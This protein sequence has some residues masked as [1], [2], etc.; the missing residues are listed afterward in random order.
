MQKNLIQLPLQCN[1]VIS[2]QIGKQL[3]LMSVGRFCF[4]LKV[5]SH[6][7]VRSIYHQ[8][9][10]FSPQYQVDKLNPRGTWK[11]GQ[12]ELGST[13]LNDHKLLENYWKEQ[14]PDCWNL[15]RYNKTQNITQR[16]SISSRAMSSLIL[17][18]KL[19]S[20]LTIQLLSW[21]ICLAVARFDVGFRW[22]TCGSGIKRVLKVRK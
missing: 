13:H 15:C 10:L 17:Q 4:N 11:V 3:R 12:C 9:V 19:V 8:T 5:T 6:S 14:Q 2:L 22:Q 21:A 7:S 18:T 1:I 16:R 20:V